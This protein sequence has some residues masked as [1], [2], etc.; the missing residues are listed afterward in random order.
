MKDLGL[1]VDD[2]IK[3]DLTQ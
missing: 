3:N 2:N 1:N